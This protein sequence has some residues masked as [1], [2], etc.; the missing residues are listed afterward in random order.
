MITTTQKDFQIWLGWKLAPCHTILKLNCQWDPMETI[1]RL[2]L[3]TWTLTSESDASP[4]S[5]MPVFPTLANICFGQSCHFWVFKVICSSSRTPAHARR[6]WYDSASSSL[7]STLHRWVVSGAELARWAVS[8]LLRLTSCLS[9]RLNSLGRP[10]SMERPFDYYGVKAHVGWP[11]GCIRALTCL[12]G[13]RK[14]L[15]LAE[16]EHLLLRAGSAKNRITRFTRQGS[17]C[18][19]SRSWSSFSSFT[20]ERRSVGCASTAATPRCRVED[21]HALLFIPFMTPKMAWTKPVPIHE[22]SLTQTCPN[23]NKLSLIR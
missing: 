20:L 11:L 16:S 21:D 2:S 7:G 4:K 3:G 18:I 15:W 6:S 8:S 12:F 23:E 22:H 5:T 13:V 19:F 1:A 14:F 9:A 17:D 10:K